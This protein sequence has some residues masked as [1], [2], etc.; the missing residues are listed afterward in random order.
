[1]YKPPAPTR[2]R[3]FMTIKCEYSGRGSFVLFTKHVLPVDKRSL[4][5]AHSRFS[6]DARMACGCTHDACIALHDAYMYHTPHMSAEELC[7]FEP[8]AV[9][10]WCAAAAC[11]SLLHLLHPPTIHTRHE[12][13]TRSMV[14]LTDVGHALKGYHVS[15]SHRYAPPLRYAHS[16]RPSPHTSTPLAPTCPAARLRCRSFPLAGLSS[17]P[18]PLCTLITSFAAH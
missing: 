8:L 1:M 16:S 7:R 11:P 3:A 10:R 14:H 4:Q 2:D 13:G 17:S 5:A 9:C 12:P 15:L 6:R 18:S